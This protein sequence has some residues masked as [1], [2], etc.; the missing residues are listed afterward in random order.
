MNQQ[1]LKNVHCGL[2]LPPCVD[3]VAMVAGDYLYYHYGCDGV[4]D[5][6]W[7]CGYRTLQTLCSW[8]R[9]QQLKKNEDSRNEPSIMD[10]QEALV[11]MQD[12][13]ERFIGSKDWIGSFEVCL[14]L[15][16]IYNDS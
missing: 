3:M 1:L 16:Y 12:K 8:L 14:C 5:R 13:P 9:M 15:D 2:A 4:D 10:I 6:G 7:G 11:A